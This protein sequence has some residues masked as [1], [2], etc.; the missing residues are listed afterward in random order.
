MGF[1][2]HMYQPDRSSLLSKINKGKEDLPKKSRR[3]VQQINKIDLIHQGL[4][5][6]AKRDASIHLTSIH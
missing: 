1:V 4:E 6:V 3:T 5:S 2:P